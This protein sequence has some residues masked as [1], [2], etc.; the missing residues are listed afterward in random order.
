MGIDGDRGFAYLLSVF[1]VG[2]PIAL[3]SIPIAMAAWAM[4]MYKVVGAEFVFSLSL[5]SIIIGVHINGN[6]LINFII[7]KAWRK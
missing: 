3:I 1:L 5:I 7:K 6:F 2:C 4:G